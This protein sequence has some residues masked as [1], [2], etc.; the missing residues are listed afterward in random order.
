MSGISRTFTTLAPDS[1]TIIKTMQRGTVT[2]N[3]GQSTNTA[4]ISAVT[5]SKASLRWHGAIYS[6]AGALPPE[7]TQI[8]LSTSTTVRAT[9]N[10][11]PIQQNDARYEVDE[12]P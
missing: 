11:T 5:M 7:M 8:D 3:A 6:G 9:R 4:T 12:K 1:Y 2:I 10:G